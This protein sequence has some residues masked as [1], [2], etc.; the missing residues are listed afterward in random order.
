[1]NG[2]E[3]QEII[4]SLSYVTKY[5][6]S[7]NNMSSKV[8]PDTIFTV[9]MY[10]D[11]NA[12]NPPLFIV[13]EPEEDH[14]HIVQNASERLADIIFK[15]EAKEISIIRNIEDRIAKN[16]FQASLIQEM[17]SHLAIAPSKNDL[18]TVESTVMLTGFIYEGVS[19]LKEL[20]HN[21]T[22]SKKLR[23]LLV[24][25]LFAEHTRHKQGSEFV[26]LVTYANGSREQVLKDC[27][28][29]NFDEAF[30]INV[31]E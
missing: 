23:D 5:N 3:A 18:N 21:R 20:F 9:K 2:K 24:N 28:V 31:L 1:M 25:S 14:V 16:E 13:S 26:S 10:A 27:S 8:I 11:E 4:R 19:F 15:I 17:I 30:G 29:S 7:Y 12:V 6:F 22:E